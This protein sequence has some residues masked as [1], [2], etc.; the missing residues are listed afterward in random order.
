MPAPSGQ[1]MQPLSRSDVYPQPQAS[2]TNIDPEL[3]AALAQQQQL[4]E[5]LKQGDR[6]P[7]PVDFTSYKRPH[8]PDE[9]DATYIAAQPADSSDS[10][11]TAVMRGSREMNGDVVMSEGN[12]EEGEEERRRKRAKRAQERKSLE[13]Q[14]RLLEARRA[15]LDGDEDEDEGDDGGGGSGGSG[16][17]KVGAEVR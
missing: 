8:G 10:A 7:L 4:Q 1:D 5:K 17:N 15:A 14:I 2:N 9:D 12:G 13:E 6:P 11:P 3:D 16:V